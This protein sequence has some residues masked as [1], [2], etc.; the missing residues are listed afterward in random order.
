MN[1][2]PKMEEFVELFIDRDSGCCSS[3]TKMISLLVH[4]SVSMKKILLRLLVTLSVTKH[5]LVY[6]RNLIFGMKN[7]TSRKETKMFHRLFK[8][9]LTK[10][11]HHIA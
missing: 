1:F 7:L 2:K 9:V 4:P 11:H 8:I 10:N 3:L 5:M 6:G